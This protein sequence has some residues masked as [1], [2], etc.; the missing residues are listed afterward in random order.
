MPEEKLPHAQGVNRYKQQQVNL[1]PGVPDE[2]AKPYQRGFF[3]NS[4]Y[5]LKSPERSHFLGKVN[6][7]GNVSIRSIS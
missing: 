1:S 7:L 5:F 4:Y 3:E 6:V 2:I